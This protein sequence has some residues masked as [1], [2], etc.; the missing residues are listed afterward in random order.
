M[1]TYLYVHINCN[2]RVYC[3]KTLCF[4]ARSYSGHTKYKHN[5]HIMNKVVYNMS[6]FMPFYTRSGSTENLDCGLCKCSSCMCCFS[7]RFGCTATQWWGYKGR[8]LW[9]AE[10]LP[11]SGPWNYRRSGLSSLIYK[12]VNFFSVSNRTNSVFW[13]TSGTAAELFILL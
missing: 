13:S 9:A 6:I 5:N 3:T 11:V 7:S 1:S 4:S 2:T 8:H 10:G 12:H